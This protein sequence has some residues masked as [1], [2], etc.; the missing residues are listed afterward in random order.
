M[1]YLNDDAATPERGDAD[2]DGLFYNHVM[3]GEGDDPLLFLDSFCLETF[4][5]MKMG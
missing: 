5:M 4:G 3:E 1:I 2:D